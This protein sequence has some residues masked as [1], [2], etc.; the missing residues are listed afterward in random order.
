MKIAI[1][2]E[3][4][5]EQAFKPFLSD[6]LKGYL[7]GRMPNLDFF[8]LHGGLPTNEKLRRIVENLLSGSRAAD[9]VIGL[10]DVYTGHHPPLFTDAADAKQKMNT[11]VGNNP[12]FFPHTA[13]HDFEAWLIPYWAK[14]QRL[15]KSNRARPGMNPETVNHNNP[16]AY[17]IK[18]IFEVG[19]CKESYSKTIYGPRILRGEN[20][21]I[22]I[23]ECSEF[24][25]FVNRIIELSG[26][27]PIQ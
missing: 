16:P 5:T 12:N 1:L 20:L 6:F 4:R 8:P 3:G 26:G 22:S 2:I 21:L 23:N 10:T 19:D 18:E 9:R 7:P 15:A 13:L 11:W 25:A 24:K 27:T 17:R 14:I